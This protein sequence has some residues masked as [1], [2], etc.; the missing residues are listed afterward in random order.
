MGYA[1]VDFSTGSRAR[2]VDE[3]LSLHG[4]E[5]VDGQL[6]LAVREDAYGD[7]LYSFLQAVSEVQNVTRH[8]RDTTESNFTTEFKDLITEIVPADSAEFDWHDNLI[9]P[10][11]HYPVD[12]RVINS[13]VPWF[14]FGITGTQKCQQATITCMRYESRQYDFNSLAIFRDQESVSRRAVAQ[15]SDV[16]GKQF[17][18]LSQRDRITDFFSRSILHT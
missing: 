5:D 18:S 7:A 16:I 1:G 14:V 2:V 17:S 6:R 4:I 15:L 11:N 3:V 9:D 12:C 10:D 8:K 13:G